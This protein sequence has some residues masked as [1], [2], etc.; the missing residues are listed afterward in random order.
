MTCSYVCL[1]V[2]AVR[3]CSWSVADQLHWYSV[4]LWVSMSLGCLLTS[5]PTVATMSSVIYC[6]FDVSSSRFHWLF[7]MYS[8]LLSLTKILDFWF[9]LPLV[10]TCHFWN[11][12]V[13]LWLY[14]Y[15]F[16]FCS[17]NWCLCV[18]NYS[19]TFR[20]VTRIILIYLYNVM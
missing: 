2:C 9:L 1:L 5:V 17:K 14:L 15:R 3:N 6:F 13:G 10:G 12:M 18:R 7:L 20:L 11:Y 19:S 8:T 4:G 16:D